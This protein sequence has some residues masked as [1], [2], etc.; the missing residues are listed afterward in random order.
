MHVGPEPTGY[1]EPIIGCSCWLVVLIVSADS[2]LNGVVGC[3]LVVELFATYSFVPELS[4]N[5]YVGSDVLGNMVARFV[6]PPL[7]AVRL[8]APVDW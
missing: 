5:E 3:V 2:E 4:I 6:K 7:S 1:G 8:H